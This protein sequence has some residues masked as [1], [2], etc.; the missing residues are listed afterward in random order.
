MQSLNKNIDEQLLKIVHAKRGFVLCWPS[1]FIK[2]SNIP[3][4][5]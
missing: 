3:L 2:L 5:L 1:N 4:S